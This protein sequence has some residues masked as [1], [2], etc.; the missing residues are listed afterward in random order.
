MFQRCF[1]GAVAAIGLLVAYAGQ[2]QSSAPGTR[3]D[4]LDPKA[5]VPPVQHRSVFGGYKRAQDSKV[6][7]WR[8]AN[9]T[10]TAI[11][12]W[13]FYAREAQQPDQSANPTNV[14]AAPTRPAD[15]H[16]RHGKP[17]GGGQ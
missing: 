2:A 14:P 5:V 4:P 11:G 8:D 17:S 1:R 9:D 6:G 7:S 15:G 3:N 12:G 10:V 13:R 16:G